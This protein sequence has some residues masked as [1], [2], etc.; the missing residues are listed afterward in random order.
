MGSDFEDCWWR[1]FAFTWFG[2]QSTFVWDLRTPCATGHFD[3][4]ALF[5]SLAS[6]TTVPDEFASVFFICFRPSSFDCVLREKP[7]SLH[8][9]G[10]RGQRPRSRAASDRN[11]P[12]VAAP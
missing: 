6:G 10:D 12:A 8:G 2:H 4:V 11:R 3:S 7:I 9:S 5:F 1:M